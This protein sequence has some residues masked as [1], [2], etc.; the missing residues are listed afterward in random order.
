MRKSKTKLLIKGL[1]VL[2]VVVCFSCT[3][4]QFKKGQNIQVAFL[5]DVHLQDIYG[6]FQDTDYKGVKNTKTGKFT[7]ART[8]KS[9]LESTR[10]FNENYYAFLS[11]LDDVAARGVKY[12]VLP[13][14]FSDDGQLINIRGLQRILAAYAK[15]HSINFLLT[16]GNHDP[17]KPFFQ[18]AGKSDFLGEGGKAQ[19][20][21]SSSDL[22]SVQD[23]LALPLVITKDIAKLGYD[24]ILKELHAFGFFPKKS[25]VYWETPFTNY[26]YDE[27]SFSTAASQAVVDN[28]VYRLPDTAY[29]IPDVSYLVEPSEDLWFLAIDANVYIPKGN[30][31]EDG[32]TPSNYGS[33][34]VGYNHVLTHKKHLISWVN[35]VTKRAEQLGKTLITFSHYPMVDFNDDASNELKLLFGEDK[36][37]LHR[38][39]NDQVAEAF[40]DAGLKI[41]FG[42]HMHSND[43]GVRTTK[44]GNKLVNIQ[45]PSLAAYI[46]AYKLLTIH[47]PTAFEIETIVIDSV[48]GF[49]DL[50]PLYEEEYRHLKETKDS[51]SLW[52]ANV[53]T[54]KTYKEFTQWHLKEL[55][56]LRFLPRDWPAEFKND[57]VHLTGE[58]LMR[59]A[60]ND[61]T[62]NYPEYK[63][64]T[65]A[66]MIFDFYQLRS[67]D[68]M[69]V[70]DIGLKRLEQ[71]KIVCDRLKTSDNVQ[72]ALWGKIFNKTAAG[73]PSNHFK[74]NLNTNAM[75]RISPQE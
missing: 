18:D 69:A 68:E 48:Q 46:P 42:G 32:F 59:L 38:V 24:E 65:G 39:P 44:L 31:E 15:E 40:A 66:D 28:R 7:L 52:N 13:G 36:M 11:A 58:D 37:Q 3:E 75:Q 29:K 56:R 17:V 34:S 45:I 53:L 64:W 21:F 23:T 57:L 26:T 1:Y 12:V 22:Y 6:A 51:S 74:I 35:T 2:L 61:K 73:Q 10:L 67:A 63:E 60:A 33:A 71:Y 43:T 14:D 54:A 55:V 30:S 70:P 27:Y 8:M 25:D 72:F 62:I 4:K 19:P 47:S 50:F 20:I 49:T 5:A 41:H 16:T 9:Q